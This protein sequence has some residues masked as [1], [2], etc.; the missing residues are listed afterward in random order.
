MNKSTNEHLHN[1]HVYHYKRLLCR[2]AEH[3]RRPLAQLH[4]YTE[5]MKEEDP[6]WRPCR[7]KSAA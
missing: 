5:C 4:W 1:W 2:L 3:E 7:N 6:N